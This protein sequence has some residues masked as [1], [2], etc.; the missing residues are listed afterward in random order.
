M[1]LI[2]KLGALGALF[3]MAVG[4]NATVIQANYTVHTNQGT[5]LQVNSSDIA[6]N[7]FQF[8]LNAGEHKTFKLFDIYTN[9]GSVNRDDQQP[10]PISVDFSFLQPASG[11]ATVNGETVGQTVFWG[12]FQNGHVSWDDPAQFSFGPNN[13][14]LLQIA[15]ADADFN[16]G[17][18]GLWPGNCFGAAIDATISLLSDATPADVPEP[19]ASALFA[20][21]LM[22]MGLVA[23]RRRKARIDYRA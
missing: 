7:P 2:T 23:Y 18:G 3:F 14:G 21:A 9:E 10:Q 17:I 8:D 1:K 12:L 15:L 19:N 20:L 4:A 13:D 16:K 5:G 6:A 22:G 11:I